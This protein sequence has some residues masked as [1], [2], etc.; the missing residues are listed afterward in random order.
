MLPLILP[1]HPFLIPLILS[2]F[3]S[4]HHLHTRKGKHK[5]ARGREGEGRE[6]VDI[7]MLGSVIG[8]NEGKGKEKGDRAVKE[9]GGEERGEEW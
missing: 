7:K 4:L 1:P 9:R 5:H 3:P 2:S 8:V 6:A